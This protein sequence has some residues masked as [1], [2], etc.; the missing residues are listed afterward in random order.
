MIAILDHSELDME[1]SNTGMETTESN[2][3]RGMFRK[4]GD[5]NGILA[6]MQ[7]RARFSHKDR[8]NFINL[9]T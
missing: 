8:Q 5:T 3:C 1:V 2:D 7:E 6:T 4:D 9:F